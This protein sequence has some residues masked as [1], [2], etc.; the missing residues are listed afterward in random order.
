MDDLSKQDNTLQLIEPNKD[1]PK[2]FDNLEG[3]YDTDT[4]TD[5]TIY[6]EMFGIGDSD[7]IASRPRPLQ[8][9]VDNSM[10]LCALVV[11]P[12]SGDKTRHFQGSNEDEHGMI[13]WVADQLFMQ[14]QE[15][16]DAAQNQYK[17][18]GENGRSKQQQDDFLSTNA[19]LSTNPASPVAV[20]VTFHEHYG[21]IITDLLNPTNRELSIKIDPA[22]GYCVHG[23]TK[24]VVASAEELKSKLDYG[25]N[26]RNV[27]MFS[28]GPANEST[29]GIFEVVL[30]QEEGDGPNSM[31]TMMSRLLFVDTPPTTP[32][33]AGAEKT[34]KNKGPDLAK[35]LFTFVDVCKALSS[36]QKRMNA[37]FEQSTFTTVLHDS[38]GADA[39]VMCLGTLCQ[40]EPEVSSKTM[41]LLSQFKK[42]N[43]YPIENTEL[44]QGIMIKYRTAISNLLDRIEELK[45]EVR[46]SEERS[47][48]R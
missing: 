44:T 5:N 3:V 26:S 31:Q 11:G 13:G 19:S 22:F 38:L 8:A 43:N 36:K 46:W 24:H 20:S 17:A 16:E 10:S 29:G 42:I 2:E 35:S 32:L 48:Q 30:K 37:P 14:L 21:E 1:K 7:E 6:S 39:L 18:T 4:T 40:G 25:K 47:D 45:V 12:T 15:K 33:V 27:A 28:T 41:K 9:F 23:I 34:R